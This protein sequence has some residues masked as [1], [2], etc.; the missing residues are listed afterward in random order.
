[1]QDGRDDDSSLA[2]PIKH[3]VRES[4]SDGVPDVLVNDLELLGIGLDSPNRV[5]DFGNKVDAEAFPLPLVPLGSS[6]N[7]CFRATSNNEL[8]CHRFRRM[9]SFALGQGLSVFTGMGPS[10]FRTFPPPA[11]HV[12]MF[13]A[14]EGS[15][16]V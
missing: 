11:P 8:V 6:S 9:S 13:L 1:M 10:L 2:D 14:A 16:S 5:V 7:V 4:T 12:T 3:P 15:V